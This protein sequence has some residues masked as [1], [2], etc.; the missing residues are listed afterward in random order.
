MSLIETKLQAL[1]EEYPEATPQRKREILF[2]VE[3]IKRSNY[4]NPKENKNDNFTKT[5]IDNLM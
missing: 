3:T 1:R 2:T 4:L 5:V